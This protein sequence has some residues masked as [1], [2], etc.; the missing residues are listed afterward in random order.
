MTEERR[1]DRVLD[2][3]YVANLRDR[4]DDEL[5]MMRAE[6]AEIETEFSY[7]RRVAQGRIDIYEAETER[8]RTGGSIADLVARLPQILAD[9][10]RPEPPKTRLPQHLA[11]APNIEWKR[12][13]EA[14]INDGT[15]ANLPALS[16]TDL[17]DSLDKT[18]EL[19]REYSEKRHQ[20]H[21]VIDTI[22]TELTAR[23]RS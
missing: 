13:D 21:T 14:L 8:R 10:P 18:R 23:L 20:I 7:V 5:R 9:G 15:L 12:G 16:D 4:S 11:P 17:A 19:E 2:P 1:I 22:E 6:C 3:S